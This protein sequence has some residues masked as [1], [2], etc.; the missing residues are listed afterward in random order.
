MSG[1]RAKVLVLAG[2]AEARTLCR[3]LAADPVFDVVASLAGVTAAPAAMGAPTRVGGFGGAA[4]LA[5]YLREQGVDAVVDA[6][7]PF[8]AQISANAAAAAADAGRPLARLRRP[9][10]T[11]VQGDRWRS[12]PSL[13]AALGYPPKGARVF[14]ATGRTSLSAYGARLD[15]RVVAR[16]IDC[17]GARAP[18]WIEVIAGRPSADP[19]AEARLLSAHRIDWVIAKNAGGVAG[20]GKIAAARALGIDVAM[21]ARPAETAPDL[22]AFEQVDDVVAWLRA[23]R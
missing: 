5:A 13:A 22:P 2:A 16:V 23:A 19:A 20:Y 8:A 18:S 11:P 14:A 10:W 6:T 3:R 1:A 7:H 17:P 12:A 21:I 4:G 15:L 9:S